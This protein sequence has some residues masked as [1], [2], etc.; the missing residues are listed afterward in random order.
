MIELIVVIAITGFV[1][2]AALYMI[3]TARMKGRDGRRLAD[4]KQLQTALEL[5]L[6]KFG[7]YPQGDGD[8]AGGWDVGNKDYPFL[9]NRMLEVLDK[10]PRDPNATGK[11]N[12][13]RY[14]R[15]SEGDYGCPTK[16]NFYVLEIIDMET[17][18]GKHPASEGFQCGT[19]NWTGEGEYIK[20]KFEKN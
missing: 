16:G 5:Y 13:Y 12:G 8:G 4:M 10:P 11:A 15:Y 18:S 7:V 14:Y 3:N 9:N 1:I 20:G 2:S 19:R 6:D 17:S